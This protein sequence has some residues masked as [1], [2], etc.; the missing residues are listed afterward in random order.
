[1]S[2]IGSVFNIGFGLTLLWILFFFGWRPYRI[3]NVRDKLFQL[4][5]ELFLLAADGGVSFDDPAYLI[6]RN[7]INA[8]IRF[9]HTITLTRSFLFGVQAKEVPNLREKWLLEVG[10]LPREQQ[11]KLIDID[12]RAAFTLAWQVFSGS[13][14]LWLIAIFYVPVLLIESARESKS[15]KMRATKELRVELIEEQAVI[16]FTR[17]EECTEAAPPLV[18]A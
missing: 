6:L 3:D 11:Q 9:A 8:V 1:M 13:P 4:R 10:K 2:A 5:S 16:K 14:I 7:R 15:A 18:H 12:Q 17:E